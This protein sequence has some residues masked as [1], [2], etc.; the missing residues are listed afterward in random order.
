MK[1]NRFIVLLLAFAMTFSGCQN[2]GETADSE[3]LSE[4]PT[5]APL[6]SE[7]KPTKPENPQPEQNKSAE[8]D[9]SL[10]EQDIEKIEKEEETTPTV[11][12]LLS[13]EKPTKPENP[14][15]EQNKSAESDDSLPE[16]DIEKIEKEEE[17][18]QP[19]PDSLPEQDAEK[20]EKEEETTQPNPDTSKDT[21]SVIQDSPS[22]SSVLEQETYNYL[23][24]AQK[25]ENE[26]EEETTQ[27]NPDTSKDTSSV[28]QD[29]PSG[30]SVLEQE[31]YN[32]L[33]EAQKAEK[34]EAYLRSALSPQ[35]HGGIYLE[36]KDTVKLY[37]WVFLPEKLDAA[38][39]AYQGEPFCV[40]RLQ[41]RCSLA[42]LQNFAEQIDKIDRTETQRL[43]PVVSEE[44]NMLTANLSEQGSDKFKKEIKQIARDLDIP[45][46]CFN[47][48]IFSSENPLT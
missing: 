23:A 48:H 13:E 30:S 12:P 22:G 35:N 8:S 47:F 6:L 43:I 38:L 20:A 41:A 37:V 29:S 10:P 19:N 44:Y 31:T 3:V 9:D 24:E 39:S 42:Q 14:Q 34:L 4:N 33:A 28:I 5:V 16:Q 2:V 15:P 45:Q 46:E 17:T 18:T 1:Q 25:A 21:S 32:Y 27:P 7:E 26:K 36:K 40:E 11:A